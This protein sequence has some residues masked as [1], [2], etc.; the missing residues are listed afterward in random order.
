MHFLYAVPHIDRNHHTMSLHVHARVVVEVTQLHVYMYVHV[1]GHV[2]VYMYTYMQLE[3]RALYLILHLYMTSRHLLVRR[4]DRSVYLV[5]LYSNHPLTLSLTLVFLSLY[6][7]MQL[8]TNCVSL[9]VIHLTLL[10]MH[11]FPYPTV[12]HTHNVILA[13]VNIH[14]SRMVLH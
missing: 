11:S 7:C 10:I 14:K 8:E 3:C 12:A 13:Q 1:Y 2:R 5:F 4:R 6:M 9:L